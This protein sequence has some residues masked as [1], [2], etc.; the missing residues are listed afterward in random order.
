MKRYHPHSEASPDMSNRLLWLPDALRGAGL[1]VA[2]VDGWQERGNENVGRTLGVICHYTATVGGGN[3]PTLDILIRGREDLPGPLS[4]LGLGR[5]GTYY[6]IA[7]GRANHAGAGEWNGIAT[8]NSSFVGI[9]AE[10]SGRAS[11]GWPPAQLDAYKRGVAAI[12][13]QVGRTAASCC[14][15]KEFA[16]PAGRK[17]DPNLDMNLFRQSVAA[18]LG[19]S[20]PPPVLIPAVEPGGKARPTLRR[21]DTGELV[22]ELQRKLKLGVVNGSFGPLTEAAVRAFQRDHAM[23][24]DGIVGPKSWI[25]LDLAAQ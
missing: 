8:G 5:D 12:L 20:A 13:R 24:P 11:E 21:G 7:S 2:L 23:V 22:S 18:I 4:Q 17:S 1:K 3:M 6:V 9:E 19:G 15:H 25:Q 10:N 16:L 14:G